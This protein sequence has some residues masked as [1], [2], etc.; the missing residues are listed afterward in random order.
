MSWVEDRLTEQFY[1]WELRGRGTQI[2]P[3][4][5]SPEPPFVPFNGYVLPRRENVDTGKRHTAISGFLERL[6][7]SLH[8]PAPPVEPEPEEEPEPNWC[9]EEAFTEFRVVLPRESTAKDTAV[10]DFLSGVSLARHSLVFEMVGIAEQVVCQ[11]CATIDDAPMLEGQLTAHFPEGHFL[12]TGSAL[13]DMWLSDD[14]AEQAVI[15]FALSREFMLPLA[16]TRSDLLVGLTGTLSRLS[17]GECGV[18]QVIFTPLTEP[19]AEHAANA[20][21]DDEG[22]PVF[23]NRADLLKA[24][25]EKF[26][27]PLYGAV[28]RLAA[29]STDLDRVWSIIREMA[30]PLRQFSRHHGNA[31]MPVL[32]DEYPIEEHARDLLARQSRRSGMILNLEELMGFVHLPTAAVRSKNSC[33]WRRA[34]GR[35]RHAQNTRTACVSA[36]TSTQA[37]QLR[38]GSMTNSVC[39]TCM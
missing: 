23:V 7:Q 22:Q 13:S 24:A 27:L 10:A 36:S 6:S 38:C 4:P 2:F 5:V 1:R 14:D 30:A 33:V 34:Q 15:E 25:P 8:P 28:V 12:P 18:Y 31:L 26:A 17:S 16:G 29:R 39:G 37:G 9:G 3:A 20:I 32:N 35:H 19:W 21:M 11:F